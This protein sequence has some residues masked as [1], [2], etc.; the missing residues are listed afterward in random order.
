MGGVV[1]RES[2][3]EVLLVP[4]ERRRKW[5][6]KPFLR[7]LP[8]VADA[9]VESRYGLPGLLVLHGR[10]LQPLRRVR[11]HEIAAQ[12]NTT[13][14]RAWAVEERI[15]AMFAKIF[16]LDHYVT[17]KFRIREEFLL[18]LRELEVRLREPR[19]RPFTFSDW[20]EC[21]RKFWRVRPTDLSTSR[22][23][24]VQILNYPLDKVSPDFLS[25][26]PLEE[27]RS[28]PPTAASLVNPAGQPVNQ[29]EEAE[30]ETV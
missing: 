12:L 2:N 18:P 28:Y 9:A 27:R 10:L 8:N 29:T 5:S 17:A 20:Q 30:Q 14:Q 22:R 4:A 24:I 19:S 7:E 16:F 25:P 11:L 1:A 21:L 23:L 15:V 6:T 3:P 26:V 13:K